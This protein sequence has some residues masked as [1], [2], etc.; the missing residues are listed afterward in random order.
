MGTLTE[1]FE[2]VPPLDGEPASEDLRRGVDVEMLEL[3]LLADGVDFVAWA[4][5]DAE[6]DAGVDGP[7]AAAVLPLVVEVP[8]FV[9]AVLGLALVVPV[10]EVLAPPEACTTLARRSVEDPD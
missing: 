4:D 9:V 2:V 5:D 1:T 8:A 6:V 7:E 3:L 10:T